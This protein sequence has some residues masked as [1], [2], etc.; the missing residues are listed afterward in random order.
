MDLAEAST[1]DKLDV[2]DETHAA[3]DP[4]I[5]RVFSFGLPTTWRHCLWEE[6]AGLTVGFPG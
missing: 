2:S 3:T 6:N 5:S 1:S 4:L